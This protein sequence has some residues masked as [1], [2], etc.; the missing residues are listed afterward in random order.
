[1]PFV[2]LNALTP[3]AVRWLWP[4]RLACGYLHMADGDPGQGKSLVLCD[5]AARLTT[6][7]PWPDGAAAGAAAAE[8]ADVVLVNAEDGARDSLHPRLV[9]AGADLGRVHVWDHAP[10]DTWL[11]LPHATAL[12]DGLLASTGARLLI[13]DPVM[14]FLDASVATTSDVSV[15]RALAPLAEL[16]R[17]RDCAVVLVRHLTKAGRGR[18][19]T[20]GQASIAFAAACR[21]VWLFGPDPTASSSVPASS[22]A[23]P[24]RVLVQAKNN[25][26]PVPPALAYALEP[27]AGAARVRW[28][29]ECA[30]T[31][32]D[33]AGL[34][35][36]PARRQACGLLREC[37]RNGPQPS[38]QVYAA[39]RP[40]GVSRRALQRAA[41]DLG[42]T[43]R[44]VGF[45]S[46]QVRWWLL[47]GQE[48]PRDLESPLEQELDAWFARLEREPANL[49]RREPPAPA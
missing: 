28:L 7:H 41:R 25:L 18:A 42:V 9:S 39:G 13:L 17:R 4:G 2:R 31:D 36:H 35:P 33:L 30:C 20:R 49:G 48:L 47:P 40:Y 44:R 26:D 29:G 38:L 11:R 34:V 12:L 8:P 16:A 19:L 24:T 14:A 23:V 15:R 10:G 37:L 22:L 32:A 45:G 46:R 27:G 43:F 5:V 21:I 3:C 1:M 6:G